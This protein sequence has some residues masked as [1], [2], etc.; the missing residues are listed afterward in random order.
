MIWPS[1]PGC[2]VARSGGAEGEMMDRAELG[3]LGLQEELLHALVRTDLDSIS[4]DLTDL[5][6]RSEN[7]SGTHRKS[8]F[9]AGCMWMS[10]IRR[11]HLKDFEYLQKK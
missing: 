5:V 7:K 1:W 11:R 10:K 3:L 9:S 8:W 2:V 4:L 6:E